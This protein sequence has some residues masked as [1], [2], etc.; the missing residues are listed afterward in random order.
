[1]VDTRYYVVNKYVT[2]F[3]LFF[4]IRMHLNKRDEANVLS[5]SLLGAKFLKEVASAIIR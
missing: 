4:G 3:N 2:V 1:M 5:H